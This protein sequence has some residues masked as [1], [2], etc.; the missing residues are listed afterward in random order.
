[1][2][3]LV[4][5]APQAFQNTPFNIVDSIA[6]YQD[7]LFLFSKKE[8]EDIIKS[9]V[10]SIVMKQPFVRPTTLYGIIAEKF[11]YDNV[12]VEGNKTLS[13]IITEIQ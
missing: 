7:L 6:K 2:Q 4:A 13:D 5:F 12:V 10:Y 1:M 11:P 3:N 9:H 8:L